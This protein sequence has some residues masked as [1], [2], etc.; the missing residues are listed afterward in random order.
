MTKA[1]GGAGVPAVSANFFSFPDAAMI[2]FESSGFKVSSLRFKAKGLVS[3]LRFKVKREAAVLN[4]V[5]EI[6]TFKR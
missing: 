1:Q 2:S 5:R 4:V 6:P 3:S